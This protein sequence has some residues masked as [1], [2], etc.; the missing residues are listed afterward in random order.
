MAEATQPQWYVQFSGV[1]EGPITSQTLRSL[2]EA[3]RIYPDTPIR[4]EGMT[5]TVPAGKIKGLL[6]HSAQTHISGSQVSPDH[7]PSIR[8]SHE[9]SSVSDDEIIKKN[10]IVN[11]NDS[12][13]GN[14][15]LIIAKKAI[16]VLLMIIGLIGIFS[17][18]KAII[19]Q[20]AIVVTGLWALITGKLWIADDKYTVKSS[21]AR[22]I[23]A[24]LIS[25]AP[26]SFISGKVII[27]QHGY[28]H[29]AI[30]YG[31]S[32]EVGIFSVI[33]VVSYIIYRI[34]RQV[35]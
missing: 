7:R 35:K 14:T 12:R 27:N 18:L 28:T 2:A 34:V 19:L 32:I 30:T 22:G 33:A 10:L 24:L 4:K 25:A 29:D 23:G 8:T 3:G 13:A 20:A 15:I 9:N 11:I 1:E 5:R 16:F 6:K 26:L 17:P 31:T 21:I